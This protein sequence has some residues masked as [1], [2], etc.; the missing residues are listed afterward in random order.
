VEFHQNRNPN[1]KFDYYDL[2]VERWYYKK[3]IIV[4]KEKLEGDKEG[5]VSINLKENSEF[6][7]KENMNYYGAD[8]DMDEIRK[9]HN[10]IDNTYVISKSILKSDVLINLPKLKTHKLAGV[11]LNMKNLVGTAVIKNSLP[12]HT[13][14]SPKNKGDKFPVE[15]KKNI[16]ETKLKNIA[17]KLLKRKNPLINY[18]FILIKNI[19]SKIFGNNNQIIRNGA[20]YGNDT[21]WR[22]VV[23]L[24]KILLYS[25]EEGN[26]KDKR[27]R[28]YFGLIDG[29]RGG[30]NFGPMK[31]DPV[32]SGVL[33]AGFNPVIIDVVAATIMGFDYKKIPHLNNAF[34]SKG[35]NI[36]DYQPEEIKIKSNIDNWEKNINDFKLTDTLQFEPYFGW[37]GHIE[38]DN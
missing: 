34:N 21:I 32:N 29:I 11:T 26:M 23:D 36:T 17:L 38:L 16:I 10:D 6:H 1:I 2:R 35:Y 37:K 3:G 27:Q 15:K 7:K 12:H 9:Y 28:K 25:D 31:P 18:P 33:L 14:G 24:N 4:K 30:E 5:Y 22:T 8:Y 20:W 13:L 19:M